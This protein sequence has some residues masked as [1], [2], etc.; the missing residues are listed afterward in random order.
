MG[1][2]AQ[3][4]PREYKGPAG[5]FTSTQPGTRFDDCKA[6]PGPRGADA[7]VDQGRRGMSSMPA[8]V[9][10]PD[11]SVQS[12]YGNPGSH[13]TVCLVIFKI[14]LY[15][16]LEAPLKEVRGH[17][18]RRSCFFKA[19]VI[20]V[21]RDSHIRGLHSQPFYLYQAKHRLTAFITNTKMHGLCQ[22]KGVAKLVELSALGISGPC[23]L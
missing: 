9:L 23:C 20:R 7:L 1:E 14:L 18:V 10:L 19:L 3:L 8:D 16:A 22:V 21:H 4:L 11:C 15:C 17:L 2:G 13:C 12:E 6:Q 5:R